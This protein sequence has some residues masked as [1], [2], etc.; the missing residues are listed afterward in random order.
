MSVFPVGQAT[1]KN[2]EFW[3]KMCT[4]GDG[5]TSR[6]ILLINIGTRADGTIPEIQID[7]LRKLDVWL[8]IHGEA[9]YGHPWAE[10][11]QDQLPGGATAFYTRKG[12]DLF[13]IVGGLSA[14]TASV[15]LPV[16]DAALPVQVIDEY[17]FM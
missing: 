13:A 1:G 16:V 12:R 14:G 7:R 15:R 3:L 8:K 5:S 17:P 6:R 2:V 9:I 10:K 11:Q 4:I